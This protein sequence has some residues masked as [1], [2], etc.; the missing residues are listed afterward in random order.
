[1]TKRTA[2]AVALAVL[3][4]ASV[5]RADPAD[6]DPPATVMRLADGAEV[7]TA[8][9]TRND[10]GAS[11]TIETTGL[12]AGTVVTVWA[13][14]F[15]HPKECSNGCGL[16]DFGDPDV[17][18]SLLWAA[19]HVVGGNGSGGFGGHL[20][21]E[22]GSDAVVMPGWLDPPPGLT[23]PRHAEIHFVLRSH[24]EKVE[25]LV[26]EQLSTFGGGCDN[27]PPSMTG[28]TGTPGPNTCR[29]VQMAVFPGP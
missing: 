13:G 7:G 3:L 15:N 22:D 8:A 14:V 16:D 21:L 17:G 29:N 23:N 2:L 6:H 1:M 25:G 19:G 18:A 10:S 20:E 26:S 12:D 9:L 11:F 27:T 28:N 24:G 4:P 5:V